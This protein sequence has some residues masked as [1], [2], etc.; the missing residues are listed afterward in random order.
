M[1]TD[2]LDYTLV[3]ILLIVNEENKVYPV[4]F[5]SY[6]FTIVELNYDT[7]NKKLLTIFKAF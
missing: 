5:H 1:E 4:V 6:T 3:V 2:T 7:Y